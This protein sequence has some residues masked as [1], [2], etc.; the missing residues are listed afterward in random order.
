MAI[1]APDERLPSSATLVCVSVRAFMWVW[2]FVCV[3]M[4][5]G[6][7]E[8]VIAG[9]CL[10]PALNDQLLMQWHPGPS[11]SWSPEGYFLKNT[12]YLQ[13]L[14]FYLILH[15]SKSSFEQLFNW[16]KTF[17]HTKSSLT[18]KSST[19]V[20]PVLKEGLKRFSEKLHQL[21]EMLGRAN[22]LLNGEMLLK[23]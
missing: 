1:F 7:E 18:C 10:V 9:S 15:Q 13:V 6:Y 8:V 20:K 4:G 11:V 17:T 3:F 22:M 12:P 2:M 23:K 14:L 5:R 19:G 21:H 16:R